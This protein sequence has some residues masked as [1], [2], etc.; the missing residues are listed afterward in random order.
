[1]KL[2]HLIYCK[3]TYIV[4]SLGHE[5]GRI[6]K[7]KTYYYYTRNDRENDREKYDIFVYYD[8]NNTHAGHQG[9]T[10]ITIDIIT[11]HQ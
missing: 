2:K 1:M 4:K 5:I 11:M 3:K 8:E 9:Y 6:E 10:F 7:N